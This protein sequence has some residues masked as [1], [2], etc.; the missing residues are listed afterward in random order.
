ML[1]AEW[2]HKVWQFSTEYHNVRQNISILFWKYLVD[3]RSEA[4][5]NLFWKY[6]NGKLFAVQAASV[7]TLGNGVA[8]LF[9]IF[10]GVDAIIDFVLKGTFDSFSFSLC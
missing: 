9:D 8:S 4:Q 7:S 3:I 1:A 6:N 2:L 10:C 5:L